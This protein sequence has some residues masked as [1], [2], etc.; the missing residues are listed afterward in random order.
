MTPNFK[1]FTTVVGNV[2]SDEEL[3]EKAHS[4]IHR[5]DL[6]ALLITRGEAGMSLIE[7]QGRTTHI[8]TQAQEVFDVTGAGDTVI[9][10]LGLALATGYDLRTAMNIANAAAG[11]V[12]GKLGTSTVSLKE[13]EHALHDHSI[14][15]LITGIVSEEELLSAIKTAHY[16]GE[17]IVMTN[18]CFDILHAGHIDYLQKARA[19]GDRLIVAINDDASIQRL[20]GESRPIVPLAQRMQLLNALECVDWVV[21]FSEDTPERLISAILPDTLIKGSDYKVHEIAGSKQ[22]LENGGDVITIDL[23]PGCSTSA[24]VKKIQQQTS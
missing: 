19:K 24:I 2:S 23:V 16:Q 7:K 8:P 22:V 3:V 12:V 5:L 14:P 18:G 13:L 11:V 9:A 21:P 4:L 15:P 6:E 10:S 20:K 17:N 1:E